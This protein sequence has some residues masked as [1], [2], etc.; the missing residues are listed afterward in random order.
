ML[1]FINFSNN[2][3]DFNFIFLESGVEKRCKFQINLKSMS[4]LIDLLLGRCNAIFPDRLR[5]LSIPIS[6]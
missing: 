2:E 6:S 3:I 1:I 4:V 5:Y